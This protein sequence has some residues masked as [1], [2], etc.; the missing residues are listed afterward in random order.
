MQQRRHRLRDAAEVLGD[1]HNDSVLLVLD[2]V[3]VL[4]L[5]RHYPA[6]AGV[7][8]ERMNGPSGRPRAEDVTE[9]LLLCAPHPDE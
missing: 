9:Q 7:V 1:E 2:R 3:G 4:A 6:E 5:A 8:L